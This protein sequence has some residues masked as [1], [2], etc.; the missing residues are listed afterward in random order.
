[1]FAFRIVFSLVTVACMVAGGLLFTRRSL[2][3]NDRFDA[4][5]E[6]RGYER[7]QLACEEYALFFFELAILGMAGALICQYLEG[8]LAVAG[9]IVLFAAGGA[10]GYVY[11]QHRI[12]TR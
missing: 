9:A 12:K 4:W 7:P 10:A 8:A 3:L 6:S 1:M 2:E 11:M 5:A